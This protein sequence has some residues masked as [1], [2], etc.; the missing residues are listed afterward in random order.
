MKTWGGAGG[1][2]LGQSP[3]PVGLLTGPSPSTPTSSYEASK[4]LAEIS[5]LRGA[6]SVEKEKVAH[7]ES[8][9]VKLESRLTLVETL[10]SQTSEQ[11]EELDFRIDQAKIPD[12]IS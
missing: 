12:T 5:E 9:L 1:S 6:L 10:A 4:F 7:L 8:L 3:S 11:V 2:A